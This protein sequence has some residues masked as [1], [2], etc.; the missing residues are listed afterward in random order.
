MICLEKSGQ[1]ESLT[2]TAAR[3]QQEADQP[4]AEPRLAACQAHQPVD[5]VVAWHDTH[6]ELRLVALAQVSYEVCVKRLRRYGR[7]EPSVV[8]RDRKRAPPE[9]GLSVFPELLLKCEVRPFDPAV[10]FIVLAALELIKAA[11]ELRI[12]HQQCRIERLALFLVLRDAVRLDIAV[13]QADVAWQRLSDLDVQTVGVHLY[14]RRPDFV[15]GARLWRTLVPEEDL[16]AEE[17]HRRPQ[18]DGHEGLLSR[19]WL[20]L[21]HCVK[22]FRLLYGVVAARVERVAPD[23]APNAH[24]RALEEPVFDDRFQRVLRAR[25][26]EP[27]HARHPRRRSLVRADHEDPEPSSN[28]ARTISIVSDRSRCRSRNGTLSTLDFSAI[29]KS[30]SASQSTFIARTISRI[31]RLTLARLGWL[32]RARGVAMPTRPLPGNE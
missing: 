19:R 15:G 6:D 23:D 16:V 26:R 14:H 24:P 17:Q 28:L 8:R 12:G 1:I 2:R 4:V 20:L 18:H 32:P 11:L 9:F 10:A 21:A 30:V 29:A 5:D 13:E 7:A 3:R 25:R 31:C 27:A 22:L